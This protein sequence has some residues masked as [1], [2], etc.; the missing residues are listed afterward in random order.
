MDQSAHRSSRDFAATLR[1]LVL[2][3]LTIGILGTGFELI[4]LEH[5]EDNWQ[6]AP[7]VLLAAGLPASIWLLLSPGA[8]IVR[9]FQVLMVLFVLSGFTGQWLHFS[10]NM[11]F[12]LEMYPSREGLEL[13][14]EALGGAYPSLAP[15]AMTLLGLMGIAAC[16]RHP[17][18]DSSR[19]T[20]KTKEKS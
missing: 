19:I 2:A 8:L 13:F 20:P 3:I 9:G 7:L 16:L 1:R 17:A 15:G 12:E 10:G 11:E 5:T 4:L 6:W 14:W 18:L